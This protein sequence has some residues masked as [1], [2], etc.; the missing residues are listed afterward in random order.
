MA[1]FFTVFRQGT[2]SFHVSLPI[3]HSVKLGCGSYGCVYGI[4]SVFSGPLDDKYG[5]RN[6]VV[7]IG[8]ADPQVD[9]RQ[10]YRLN[11]I[12]S[13]A[14]IGPRVIDFLACPPYFAIVM[15]RIDMTV[16]QYIKVTNS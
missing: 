1:Y 7:K 4:P 16:E 9:F 5:D 10:E 13:E 6:I 14:G 2:N 11:L 3:A 12:M 15:Q 8:I